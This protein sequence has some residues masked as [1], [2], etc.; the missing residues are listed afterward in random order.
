MK[1]SFMATLIFTAL[2]MTSVGL[3]ADIIELTDGNVISGNIIAEESS[4]II[5]LSDNGIEHSI[6]KS[7]IKTISRSKKAENPMRQDVVISLKNG[8]KITGKI[9]K[10]DDG[11]LYLID[12]NGIE[13]KVE[14][15]IIRSI[16]T[17]YDQSYSDVAF[18]QYN[19]QQNYSV[20]TNEH[21]RGKG[22]DFNFGA[23]IGYFSPIENALNDIYG[24]GL[25]IG[26]EVSVWN[27][28][29]L[30][31][32]LSIERFGASGEP[33]IYYKYD[34]TCNISILPI[35]LTGFY[36]LK[37]LSDIVNPYFGIGGGVY[38]VNEKVTVSENGYSESVSIS[39]N[40]LGFHFTAGIQYKQFFTEAKYSS[41]SVSSE[42]AS[43]SSANIGGFNI[44]IGARF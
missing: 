2:I 4:E 44:L 37:N 6:P 16:N 30:G 29:G 31:G 13:I 12:N 38:F 19:D 27:E 42:G 23:K 36:K 20:N 11:Y 24:G 8:N 43:G 3:S 35:T 40:A 15:S 9:V 5:V 33:Y 28:S 17:D 26:G 18:K 25:V 22:V 7:I 10:E 39:D 32:C 41:A 14:K 1:N 21:N 34:A